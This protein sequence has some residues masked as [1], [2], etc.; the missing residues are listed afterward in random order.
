[1]FTVEDYIQSIEVNLMK[2]SNI[3]LGNLKEV[4]KKDF[5]EDV[6]LLD[7]TAFVEPTRFEL[8]M[9][10]FLMDVDGNEVFMEAGDTGFAGSVEVL[11]EVNF[12]MLEDKQLDAF[13]EFYEENEEVL[14][15]K[16]RHIFSAWFKS[17]WE[18][19][20]G[21]EQERPSYFGLHDEYESLDLKNGDWVDDEVKWA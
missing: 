16:E 5:S 19:A 8:S 17:C 6:H 14:V 15:E 4:L 10:M 21:R 12:Y 7:F 1:M 3:L 18:K 9:M 11:P 20:G 2:Q 13:F